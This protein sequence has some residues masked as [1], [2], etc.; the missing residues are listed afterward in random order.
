MIWLSRTRTQAAL[1]W[2]HFGCTAG[3]FSDLQLWK[4]VVLQSFD[5]QR[6]TIPLWKDLKLLCDLEYVQ[7]TSGI[8]Y[9][10][11]PLSNWPHF[12]SAYVLRYLPFFSTT[13]SEHGVPFSL[14][15]YFDIQLTSIYLCTWNLSSGNWKWDASIS[16]KQK[17]LSN[18]WTFFVDCFGCF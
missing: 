14:C 4:L 7:E 5:Q 11:F 12:N 13:V 18:C 15:C 17:N 2:F 10:G 1:L 6:P 8:L 9:I 16:R 3:F